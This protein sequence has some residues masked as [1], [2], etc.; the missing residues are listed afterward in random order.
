MILDLKTSR[1]VRR[2]HVLQGAGKR[3]LTAFRGLASFCVDPR[4]WCFLPPCT[5]TPLNPKSVPPQL[6]RIARLE[7]EDEE[8]F[9]SRWVG[10]KWA[11]RIQLATSFD[12][13]NGVLNVSLS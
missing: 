7:V 2:L 13:I 12:D 9:E 10:P 4:L 1:E 11:T 3:E 5:P 8:S 6:A